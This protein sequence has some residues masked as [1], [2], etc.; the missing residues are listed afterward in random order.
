MISMAAAFDLPGLADFGMAAI[1]EFTEE[2]MAG[3][4]NA[5]AGL[6]VVS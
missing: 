2:P 3:R 5:K 1:L 6:P 4:S